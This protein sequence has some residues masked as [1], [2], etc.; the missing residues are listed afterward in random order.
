MYTLVMAS[1]GEIDPTYPA[2]HD[3]AGAVGEDAAGDSNLPPPLQPPE[4]IDRTNP[5]QPTG[6]STPYP[7]DYGENIEL[8]SLPNEEAEAF[9]LGPDHI[10]TVTELDFFD[11]EEKERQLERVKR[12]IKDKFPKVDFGK[13]GPIGLGKRLENQFKF[14]KFGGRGGESRIIK[15]DNSG[16]LKSF[17][18]SNREAVG[19][20]AEELAAEKT[21]DERALRQKLA[22][23]ERQLKDKEQQT[24]LEQKAAENVRNLT[25]RFEQTRARREAIEEEHGSN[26]EQQNEIDR[27]KQL[28]RNLK[29]DLENEKVEL[30]QLQKRQGKTL[31][32]AKRSVGKLKKDIF[33]ITKER[34]EIE[35]SL[36]RTKTLNELEER[37]ETLKRENEEDDD[38]ATSSDKQAATERIIE[39]EE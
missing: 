7:D 11:V 34:D 3:G 25:N 29:A 16:L 10:P 26:R 2:D 14:V 4:D 36:N 6:A 18:D 5:F 31:K 33:A 9:I 35:L 21:Q 15:A 13:L 30:K 12:F 22:E 38:N 19:K 37:Y 27:L 28:E 24:A 20:S 23:E 8:S 39:R 17:V 32:E 1:L